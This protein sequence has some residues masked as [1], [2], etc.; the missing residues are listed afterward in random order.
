[1]VEYNNVK[2]KIIF[3]KEMVNNMEES[4]LSDAGSLS[5][6]PPVLGVEEM[7]LY[8]L[9]GLCFPVFELSHYFITAI[10]L[11]LEFGEQSARFVLFLSA[12]P[13]LCPCVSGS[14]LWPPA[15]PC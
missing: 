6:S 8:N 3:W 10:T 13:H 11:R 4:V 9:P 14:P 5:Q 2:D 7:V 15:S 1:M 12:R